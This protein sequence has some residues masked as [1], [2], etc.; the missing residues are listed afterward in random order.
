MTKNQIAEILAQ[1]ADHETRLKQIETGSQ[2]NL[3]SPPGAGGKQK[4]LREIIKGKRFKNGQEQIAA[5]VGYHEK[6]LG[7]QITKEKIKEEWASSK[8]NGVFAA[9]FLSRAKDTFIRIHA[10]D[11]CD[12]TQSGEEFFEKLLSHESTVS[13][14]K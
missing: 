14:S 3:I 4:T 5:I 2:S 8:M 11:L 12:L 6:I 13:A 10:D 7:Q 9:V 1:L